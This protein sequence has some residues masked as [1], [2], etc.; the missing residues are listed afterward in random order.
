ME[1][2]SLFSI[3]LNSTT[4]S[5]ADDRS[6]LNKLDLLLSTGIVDMQYLR[7]LDWED[8]WSLYRIWSKFIVNLFKF[9]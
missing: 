8:R 6:A 9:S 3:Y 7:C 1:D 4:T 5:H 2:R